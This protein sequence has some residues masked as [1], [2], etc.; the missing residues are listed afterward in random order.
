M[1]IPSED[2]RL[3]C[4]SLASLG[5]VDAAA[6][7]AY[8]HLAATFPDALE[9]EYGWLY[10]RWASE[11]QVPAGGDLILF[12]RAFAQ[13]AL[14]QAFFAR[15][16]WD[17]SAVECAYLLRAAEERPGRFP[18]ALG[19]GAAARGATLLLERSRLEEEGGRLDAAQQC[20]T[21][22]LQL[23]PGHAAALDRLAC[24]HYRQGRLD[25]AAAALAELTRQSPDDP[26]PPLRRALV[27]QRRRAERERDAAVAAALER[28]RGRV[29][30]QVCWMAA[31]MHLQE[32]LRLS[33]DRNGTPVPT[34]AAADAVQRAALLLQECLHEDANHPNALGALAGVR[35]LQRDRRGL[36]ALAPR[37]GGARGTDRRGRVL[38]AVCLLTA[39]EP[40]RA[41]QVSRRVNGKWGGAAS[42]VAG[43]AALRRHDE[44]AAVEALR[45]A[46]SDEKGAAT[47]HARGLLAGLCYGRGDYEAAATWWLSVRP[48]RRA[49]WGIDEALPRAVLLGALH[50][51]REGRYEKAAEQFREAGRLGL[52]DRRLG[53]WIAHAL[54]KAGQRLLFEKAGRPD[55]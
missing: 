53:S 33:S 30:A 26:L 15:R 12:E 7:A 48:A 18:E 38:E 3:L 54:V 52:R 28:S 20:V 27:E 43:C 21:S 55:A 40:A 19:D 44:S 46:A 36:A 5:A 42:Y 39:G 47:D 37:F 31:R 22:L 13:P 45:A 29:R 51:L 34:G 17:P 4:G 8:A 10:V 25:E 1:A 14:L 41:A 50:A 49:A 32:A 23:A 11:G 9:A 16:Q 2:Q 35:W 6:A 24:L